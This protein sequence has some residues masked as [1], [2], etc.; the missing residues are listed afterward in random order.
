MRKKTLYYNDA[1][2][3]LQTIPFNEVDIRTLSV[4]YL[5]GRS[6]K[7]SYASFMAQHGYNLYKDIH[8]HNHPISLYVDDF[9]FV[10][11]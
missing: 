2:Q 8:F 7:E 3:V 11:R 5:H 4:E 9:I 1:L 10:K 6:G